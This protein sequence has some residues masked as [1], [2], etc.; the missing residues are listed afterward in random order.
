MT[1]PFC[2]LTIVSFERCE[3]RGD[4]RKQMRTEREMLCL[5]RPWCCCDRSSFSCGFV[6]EVREKKLDRKKSGR[7]RN[8]I[9]INQKWAWLKSNVV[10][11]FYSYLILH[12]KL[13]VC[14]GTVVPATLFHGLLAS[15]F[16]SLSLVIKSS[17][18]GLSTYRDVYGLC[19]FPVECYL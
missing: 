8:H 1:W 6:F 9:F 14:C 10:L 7:R 2:F 11:S 18:R 5:Y 17:V 16:P 4:L 15:P 3:T 12:H 19:P 13:I